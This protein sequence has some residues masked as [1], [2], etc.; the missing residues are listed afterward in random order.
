MEE[1]QGPGCALAVPLSLT[2][3]FSYAERRPEEKR[4]REIRSWPL[5]PIFAVCFGC[6]TA[7]SWTTWRREQIALKLPESEMP[8]FSVPLHSYSV[9]GLNVSRLLGGGLVSSTTFRRLE[10]IR[11]SGR[12]EHS[13]DCKRIVSQPWTLVVLVILGEKDHWVEN[14][15]VPQWR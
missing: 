13:P 6:P 9:T 5:G 7:C 4:E 14:N 1:D 8:G 12:R 15:L 10:A 3:C 2:S 11:V